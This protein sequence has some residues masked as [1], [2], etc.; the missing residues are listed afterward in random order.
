MVV[1]EEVKE[2]KSV[3]E[4][5]DQ[6]AKEDKILEEEEVKASDQDDDE[7]YADEQ[8]KLENQSPADS[9][10]AEDIAPKSLNKQP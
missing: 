7:D 9:S 4:E 3:D 2:M 10:V 1:Q 6:G 5:T 8:K